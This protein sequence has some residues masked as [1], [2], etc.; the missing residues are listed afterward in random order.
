MC[1]GIKEGKGING[2]W[3]TVMRR[4]LNERVGA[5]GKATKLKCVGEKEEGKGLNGV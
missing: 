1:G 3:G 5:E 4:R 2:V